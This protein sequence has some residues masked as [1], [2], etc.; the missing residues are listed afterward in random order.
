MSLRLVLGCCV[1][2]T[3]AFADCHLHPQDELR[4]VL[5]RRMKEDVETLPEKEEIVIWVQLTR[6]QL[7]YLKALMAKDV[8]M[9]PETVQACPSCVPA[10][11]SRRCPSSSDLALR[12]LDG[13]G[14]HVPEAAVSIHV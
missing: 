1:A 2:F 7:A 12:A 4:P 3:M 9:V 8:S 14:N 10:Q 6:S 13:G 5:L 11:S